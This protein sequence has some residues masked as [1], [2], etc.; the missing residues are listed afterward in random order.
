FHVNLQCGSRQG[1]DVAFHFNPRFDS[2]PGYVVANTF[3]GSRWGSEERK[4]EAPFPQGS[5]FSLTIIV[6]TDAFTVLANGMK[7]MEYKHRLNFS[8]VDTITVDGGVVVTCISFQNPVSAPVYGAP[9]YYTIPYKTAINGGMY[10]G[11]SIT[12]QGVVN[13]SAKRFHFN[14]CYGSG[15]AMHFNPR[16]DENTVVRNSLMN[17]KWG[18]E[19]R[20]GGMPFERGQPFTVT[21]ICNDQTYLVML[22][23]VQMF[24]YKHR[25]LLLQDVNM[26][27]VNGDVSLTSV[28][29]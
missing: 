11:R 15:I 27:E 26:L 7:F 8:Q 23:G 5:N 24:T 21:F 12:I 1:A 14:L 20:Q 17:N 4:Y 28:T 13:P 29:I 6:N 3:Q 2:L 10:P 9:Q 19:E 18:P 16:F 25:H 22:N